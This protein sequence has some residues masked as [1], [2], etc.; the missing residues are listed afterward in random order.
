MRLDNIKGIKTL[1]AVG[2]TTV[3]LAGAA[4]SLSTPAKAAGCDEDGR[5]FCT[6]LGRVCC[7][8]PENFCCAS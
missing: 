6:Y 7:D 1:T 8:Q 5:A 3:A 4:V 2:M